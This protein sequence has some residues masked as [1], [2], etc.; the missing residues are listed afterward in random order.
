MSRVF[1]VSTD[2]VD[3]A[4]AASINNLGAFT[5][6]AWIY[7][8]DDTTNYEYVIAVKAPLTVYIAFGYYGTAAAPLTLQLWAEGPAA[9]GTTA[10]SVANQLATLNAWQRV[11]MTY[12][13]STDRLVHI[14]LDGV[15]C[16]YSSG[17]QTAAT[18]VAVP[19]AL[20]DLLIGNDT[21]GDDFIGNIAEFELW[22]VALTAPQ[23]LADY[24]GSAVLP[25]NLVVDLTFLT[26]T[27]AGPEPD[28]SGN[29]N[30]GVFTGTTF[31]SNNPPTPSPPS[32]SK[33]TPVAMATDETTIATNNP[34]FLGT[35]KTLGALIR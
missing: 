15:E 1:A 19:D 35:L 13:D 2:E 7:P 28:A 10:S 23:V 16:T 21:Y 32:P 31:S 4:A 18:G 26:N 5:Y 3:V 29:G 14:Y 20:G 25:G 24:D 34:P 33:G 30:V 9:S 12:N 27:G 11:V 6:A 22:N 17:F 8:T